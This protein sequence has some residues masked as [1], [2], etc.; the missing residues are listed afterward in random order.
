MTAIDFFL[1]GLASGIALLTMT[2]Y[3]RVSPRWLRWLLLASGV[4]LLG[5]YLS[6]ARSYA[7]IGVFAVFVPA[8]WLETTGAPLAL[9]LPGVFAIDQLLRHPSITP[10]TLLWWYGPF[11]AAL[12]ILP[13]FP[14]IPFWHLRVLVGLFAL[15]LVGV[16]AFA[17]LKF[18][19]PTIRPALL[20][21]ILGYLALGIGYVWLGGFHAFDTLTLL[22]LWYAYDTAAEGGRGG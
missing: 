19:S 4:L 8:S 13:L 18:P 16:C 6:L 9:T 22:A 21:L 2:A 20:V 15:G 10:K 12:V 1:L 14:L 3:R 5:H 11:A 7:L 17:I